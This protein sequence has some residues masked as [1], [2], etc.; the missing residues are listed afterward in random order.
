MCEVKKNV[1]AV[2]K[3]RCCYRRRATADKVKVTIAHTHTAHTHGMNSKCGAN[4]MGKNYYFQV[5]VHNALCCI[6]LHKWE[7][8]FAILYAQMLQN[9][10]IY[11]V[12]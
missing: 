1:Q 10:C 2:W 8:S 6:M 9:K 7:R 11:C 12:Y 3:S 4:G 5:Q